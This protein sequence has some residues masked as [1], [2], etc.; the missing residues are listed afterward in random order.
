MWGFCQNRGYY[1][2]TTSFTPPTATNDATGSAI[3]SYLLGLPAVKQRQAGIPQMQLRQWYADGFVQDSFRVTATTT[4]EIGLR[5]EF[6]EPLVDISYTNSNLAFENGV[7]TAF[8]GG[9]N[10]FPKGL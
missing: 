1:Q 7:P 10:G 8:I 4:I 3:A 5:Y 6:M 2:F 9:Q